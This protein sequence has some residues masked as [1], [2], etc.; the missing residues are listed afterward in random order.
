LVRG[1]VTSLA[2][3]KARRSRQ[4]KIGR[5]EEVEQEAMDGEV[6]DHEAKEAEMGV[7]GHGN[8]VLSG[9]C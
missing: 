3:G 9:Q 7:T 2:V 4:I 8:R 5:K 1:V 6:R